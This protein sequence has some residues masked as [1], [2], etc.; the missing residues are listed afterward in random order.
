MSSYRR[1]KVP[2]GTWFFTHRLADRRSTAL[3]DHVD[4]LRDAVALTR[5]RWPFTIEAAVI[6]PDHLHMIWTLPEGDD[7]FSARWRLIKTAFSAQLPAAS[8]R[9]PRQIAKGEKGIWQRRFWEH[10]IR[11]AEDFARHRQMILESP[12]LAGLAPRPDAWRWSSVHR[13]RRLGCVTP[14]PRGPGFR[15][16]RPAAGTSPALPV[17]PHL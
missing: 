3:T 1:L 7:D 16:T 2:G 14:K 10:L 8:V 17:T 15:G 13:D 6:L 5:A 11:D 9:T 12:V 4:L